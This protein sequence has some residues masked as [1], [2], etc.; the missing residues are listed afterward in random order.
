MPVRNGR[1][2]GKTGYP[3]YPTYVMAS[4]DLFWRSGQLGRYDSVDTAYR[5]L[6]PSTNAVK[7]SDSSGRSSRTWLGNG[8]LD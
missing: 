2:W 7:D 3:G 4:G 1:K 8:F 6:E 5:I